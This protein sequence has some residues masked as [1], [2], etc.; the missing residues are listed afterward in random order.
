VAKGTVSELKTQKVYLLGVIDSY[1]RICWLEP[2]T[3]I[4]ALDISFSTLDMLTLLKSRYGIEFKEML[5][6]NGSEFSSRKNPENHPFEKM[7]SFLGIK[8]RYTQ[9]CKPQTNGKIERFW[10]TLEDELLS[11]E[12]FETLAE[13]KHYIRGYCVY[14]NEH[15]MHQGIQLKI[16]S[17]MLKS[18]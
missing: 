1:S 11:G 15:R 4:K 17:E 9:P 18:C 7:L 8:H 12:T 13:F 16:P 2:L 10:K 14:Y 3:S 6:D 5:S